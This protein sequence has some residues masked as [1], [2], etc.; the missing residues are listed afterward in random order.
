MLDFQEMANL[1]LKTEQE[2]QKFLE[3]QMKGKYLNNPRQV[4]EAKELIKKFSA[5]QRLLYNYTEMVQDW[6]LREFIDDFILYAFKYA[7][8]T[9]IMLIPEEKLDKRYVKSA[10]D[11]QRK[12]SDLY[13]NLLLFKKFLGDNAQMETSE[14]R[15]FVEKMP[16]DKR[17]ETKK[18]LLDAESE[19]AA[20]EKKS[21]DQKGV[22]EFREFEEKVIS[23]ENDRIYQEMKGLAKGYLEAGGYSE[24]SKAFDLEF[25]KDTK[26][27]K[28][29]AMKF[30]VANEEI[31]VPLAKQMKEKGVWER[32]KLIEI[33][34]KMSKGGLF[35][36]PVRLKIPESKL[37][38]NK[39]R[40][41]E[42]IWN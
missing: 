1:G 20:A 32:N 3:L 8:A 31:L 11:I 6:K 13:P 22:D 40:L 18:R 33:G 10:T 24:I 9:K 15:K 28:L 26:R 7:F 37:R 27:D 29:R 5:E 42:M 30:L 38:K 25:S 17:K 12:S 36:K 19:W 2:V 41:V 35:K 4:K 34:K 39:K 14:F 16:E 21:G 23:Y